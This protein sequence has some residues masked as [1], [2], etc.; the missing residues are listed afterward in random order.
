M[1]REIMTGFL[2]QLKPRKK[3]C[4]KCEESTVHEFAW[5]AVKGSVCPFFNHDNME[6]GC[7]GIDNKKAEK[8]DKPCIGPLRL[9]PFCLQCGAHELGKEYE[10]HGVVDVEGI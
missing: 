9:A 10:I 1:R 4:Q 7:S 8:K 2:E 5:W 6:C 3:K